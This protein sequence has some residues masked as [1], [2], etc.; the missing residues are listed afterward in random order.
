MIKLSERD[1]WILY[2]DDIRVPKDGKP[3]TIARTVEEAKS[4][5]RSQ[6][7]PSFISFDHD[8]DETASG[9]DFAK[10]LVDQDLDGV[11]NIPLD[12]DF[13]VHSANPVGAKNIE[14]I[15][16]KYLEVKRQEKP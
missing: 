11:I 1:G 7:C 14:G 6:G 4:L 9:Y 12:F 16:R 5:V 13:F 3:W 8:I 15:L 10:W 2:L